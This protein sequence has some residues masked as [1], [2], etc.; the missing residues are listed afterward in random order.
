MGFHHVDQ[1]GLDLLTSG[2]IHLP[3]PP[4]VLGL[5]AR[6][7]APSQ[8][9]VILLHNGPKSYTLLTRLECSG[10]ILVH[11]N[12]HFLGS[13]DS[14]ASASLGLTLLPRLKYSDTITAH[15]SLELLGSN[16]PPALSAVH[17]HYHSSLQPGLPELK[18]SSHLS[19]PSS[20]DYRP[21]PPC[22]PNCLFFI[23]MRSHCA[24]KDGLALLDSSYP[25]PSDSKKNKKCTL[26]NLPGSLERQGFLMTSVICPALPRYLATKGTAVARIQTESYSVT[27]AGMW[28]L[29]LGS[30]QP[31]PPRFK[32][33]RASASQVARIEGMCHHAQLIFV[34]L[35]EMGFHHVGQAGLELLAS[36]MCS[37]H[38]TAVPRSVDVS[39][40]DSCAWCPVC[41]PFIC[42]TATHPFTWSVTLLLRL[43][44]SD[45][46]SAHCNLCLL[47]SSDSP[48]SAS[49]VA[50]TI[51]TRHHSRL[52]FVFL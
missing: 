49:Q 7:T 43:E 35:V 9:T 38:R 4:K 40:Q 21:A 33:S 20:W 2:E 10:L 32:H 34:L 47:G 30:L 22:P 6:A 39:S 50:G 37:L 31:L 36:K 1:A 17:W 46:I 28:W 15:C 27:Q 26:A 18:Q 3:R 8:V 16:D 12:L 48:A 45:A 23:E 13:N 5:Q 52:M 51:G 24:A 42:H 29:S 25:P 41:S 11:C 44:C 14:P 19:L